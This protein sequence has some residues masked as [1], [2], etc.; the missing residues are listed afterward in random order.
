MDNSDEYPEARASGGLAESSRRAFLAGAA[1]L[2]GVVIASGAWA[3]P[4]FAAD[5]S[6]GSAAAAAL[7]AF[8]PLT[9]IDLTLDGVAAGFP[10]S[11][12]GGD[13]TADVINEPLTQDHIIHKHIGGVKYEDISISCGTGMSKQLYNWVK[14]SF[15]MKFAR[16][17]GELQAA[18]FSRTVRST[19]SFSNALI[20]EIG[21][22]ALDAASKDAA[23][24]SIKFSPETTRYQLG[25]GRFAG[26]PKVQKQWLPANFRLKIDGLD[27][28]RVNKIDAISIKQVNLV[29]DPGTGVPGAI[30]PA[31]LEFPNLSFTLSESTAK[32]WYDWHEDFVIKG[33]NGQKQERQGQLVYLAVDGTALF[34][35]DLQQLGIFKL[36]PDKV[37]SSA[38][39]IRRVKA[40]LYCEDIKFSHFLQ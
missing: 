12:E 23:K 9:V 29:A 24:M 31:H 33:N 7:P 38:D 22:P 35:L 36:T 6:P 32:S 19:L 3:A 1:G 17:S 2:T 26:N 30:E 13:A 27:T 39:N 28:T 25:G 8:P 21:M 14:D 5:P 18:D 34:T 10:M 20:A 15:D 37:E 40:E 16:K 4:A 11:A